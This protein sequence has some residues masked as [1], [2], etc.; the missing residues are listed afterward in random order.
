MKPKTTALPDDIS[1]RIISLRRRRV[2]LDVDL[3]RIYGV[4]TKSLN[5]AIK[6]NE[7]RF[8][9]DFCFQL[10]EEE[11]EGLRFQI[12]TSND[13]APGES[14]GGRRYRPYAFTEH[15]RDA[16]ATCCANAIWV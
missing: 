5:R 6:R 10:T 13:G 1:N 9:E 3:A 11:F 15:G 8:P 16:R 7:S 14:R 12:G 4:E 2:I